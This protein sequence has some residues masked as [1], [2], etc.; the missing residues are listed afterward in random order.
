MMPSMLPP[1]ALLSSLAAARTE[2]NGYAADWWP[3]LSMG[4]LLLL[5][6]LL[7]WAVTLV[8]TAW[9]L[10]RP[11]RMTAGR[12]LARLGRA[13]PADVGL[14]VFGEERFELSESGPADGS[15]LRVS[16]AHGLAP[17][18]QLAAWWVPHP[19]ADAVRRA[20]VMLHGYGDSRAG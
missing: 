14:E 7:L 4:L 20:C 9:V 13:T 3:F 2:V 8:W 5:I 17:Q 10:H 12:A 16:V 15:G 11:P 1:V 18:A 6:G 19:G